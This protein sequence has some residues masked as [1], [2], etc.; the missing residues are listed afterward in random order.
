MALTRKQKNRKPIFC[1]TCGRITFSD[2]PELKW[3]LVGSGNGSDVIRCPQHISEWSMRIAGKRRTMANFRW[4]RLAKE[5]DSNYRPE[6]MNI[7][8]FWLDD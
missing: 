2:S 7:E 6:L 4:M 1:G 8:P 5:A 3:W